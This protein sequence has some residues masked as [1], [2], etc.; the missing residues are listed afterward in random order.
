MTGKSHKPSFVAPCQ[1]SRTKR[2][3]S[4]PITP[5]NGTDFLVLCVQLIIKNIRDIPAPRHVVV[6]PL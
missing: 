5:T 4:I 1:V 3:H 6:T 2:H